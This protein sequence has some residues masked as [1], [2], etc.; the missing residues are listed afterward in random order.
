MICLNYILKVFIKK[1]M[2]TLI[3]GPSIWP[4]F[5]SGF[6]IFLI[7]DKLV[8]IRLNRVAPFRCFAAPVAIYQTIIRKIIFNS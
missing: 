3:R 1:S 2:I 4:M 5:A 7:R 8:P 6:K